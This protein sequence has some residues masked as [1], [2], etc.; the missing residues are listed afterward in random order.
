M[1]GVGRHACW[2]QAAGVVAALALVS[3]CGRSGAPTNVLVVSIDGV[4][5]G[6][7]RGPVSELWYPQVQS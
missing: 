3:A 1:L 5:P 7:D 2:V 6:P 4:A